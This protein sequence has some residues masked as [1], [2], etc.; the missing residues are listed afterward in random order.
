MNNYSVMT[1]SKAERH[2]Y[3]YGIWEGTGED[4]YLVAICADK[5]RAEQIKNLLEKDSN[6]PI[7]LIAINC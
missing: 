4:C 5:D 3:K 7:P 2:E 1:V 6:R